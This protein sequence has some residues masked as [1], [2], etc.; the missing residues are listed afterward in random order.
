MRPIIIQFI[1]NT[2]QDTNMF[3]K[4]YNLSKNDL[5]LIKRHYQKNDTAVSDILSLF[6]NYVI[7]ESLLETEHFLILRR[8][9]A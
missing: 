5:I 6:S 9:D 1:S 4:F 7:I 3:V 8:N 2:K